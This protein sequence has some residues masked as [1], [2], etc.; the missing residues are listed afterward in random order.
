MKDKTEAQ[1]FQERLTKCITEVYKKVVTK[2]AS[3]DEMAERVMGVID[4]LVVC[5]ADKALAKEAVMQCLIFV[6]ASMK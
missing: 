6:K 3:P 2:E 1:I 5:G 4:G